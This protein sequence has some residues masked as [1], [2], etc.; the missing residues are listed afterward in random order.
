MRTWSIVLSMSALGCGSGGGAVTLAELPN[1][2]VVVSAST[3]AHSL[4]QG[5]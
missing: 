1:P 3:G 4:L 2:S 5:G